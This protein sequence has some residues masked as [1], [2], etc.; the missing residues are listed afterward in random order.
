[1][2]DQQRIR[3]LGRDT[4]R[5]LPLVRRGESRCAWSRP[6]SAGTVVRFVV[7]ER[8]HGIPQV[9]IP[10]CA[11]E[12]PRSGSTHASSHWPLCHPHGE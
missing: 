2:G 5:M 1:M 9:P 3:S 8:V 12:G 7:R 10:A 6:P 11:P 4:W